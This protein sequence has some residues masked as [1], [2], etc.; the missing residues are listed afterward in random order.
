MGSSRDGDCSTKGVQELS[1]NGLT[2]TVFCAA[3]AQDTKDA[4]KHRL[5][6]LYS[7]ISYCVNNHLKAYIVNINWKIH[8]KKAKILSILAKKVNLTTQHKKFNCLA[9]LLF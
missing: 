1:Y 8:I 2:R 4:A 7:L 6:G 9:E 3:K 5:S